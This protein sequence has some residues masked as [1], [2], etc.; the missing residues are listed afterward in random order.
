[1]YFSDKVF[2]ERVCI[3]WSSW[4][5]STAT[6]HRSLLI[7]LKSSIK[8]TVSFTVSYFAESNDNSN[9]KLKMS[10]FFLAWF[11]LL[12][13]DLKSKHRVRQN[14]DTAYFL[15][16][17]LVNN[18]AKGRFYGTRSYLVCTIL[19]TCFDRMGMNVTLS[20]SA[21]LYRFHN[22]MY[23]SIWMKVQWEILIWNM[24]FAHVQE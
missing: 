24:G 16:E 11:I 18:R 8:S 20:S 14:S 6:I 19:N 9:N 10:F 23:H 5:S 17:G 13:L 7:R 2:F 21:F 4:G 12:Q 1:M 22:M 15:C 3:C